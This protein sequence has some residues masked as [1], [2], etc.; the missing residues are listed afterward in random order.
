MTHLRHAL[1]QR[2][3]LTVIDGVQASARLALAVAAK[4]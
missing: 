4:D 2:T 1:G 3:P